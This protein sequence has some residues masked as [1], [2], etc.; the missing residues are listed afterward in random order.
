MWHVPDAS[1]GPPGEPWRIGYLYLLPAFIVYAAFLLVPLLRAVQISFYDWD[2]NTVGTWAGLSNYADVLADPALR[3]AFGHALV[4]I[5]FFAL[6]P[7]AV[8][9]VLASILNR[10]RVRGLAFFRT[11]SHG[12]GPS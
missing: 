9:L 8:G 6:I 10:A 12:T 3:G 11:I 2:G 1:G 5:V 4:L 7:V